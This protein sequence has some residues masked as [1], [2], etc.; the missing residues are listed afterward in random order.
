VAMHH[1]SEWGPKSKGAPGGEAQILGKKIEPFS[2]F[3][4]G[5][6]INRV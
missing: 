6:G 2:T 3:L 5:L 1:K 4:D